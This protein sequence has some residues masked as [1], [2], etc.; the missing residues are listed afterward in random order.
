MAGSAGYLTFYTLLYVLTEYFHVWY[1]ASSMSALIVN[2]A[3]TFAL[4]KLWT[5]R[6]KTTH[7]VGRQVVLYA[8]MV[9]TFYFSNAVLLY[10]FVEYLSLWYMLAQA[11]ITVLL[12]IASFLISRK[13]FAP[14]PPTN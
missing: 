5:F 11:I 14:E 1:L 9:T 12:T 6:D 3:I 2:Y 4:Q 13:L 8:L 10:V 7:V